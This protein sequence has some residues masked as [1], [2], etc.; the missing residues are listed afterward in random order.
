MNTKIL[1]ATGILTICGTLFLLS[2]G[3]VQDHAQII[4]ITSG[5]SMLSTLLF[6]VAYH[7]SAIKFYEEQLKKAG[8]HINEVDRKTDPWAAQIALMK[9]SDQEL[10]HKPLINRTAILYGALIM[11]EVGETLLA[12]AQAIEASS[13]GKGSGFY[14]IAQQYAR[15]GVSLQAKSKQMRQ[16]I[17]DSRDK[18]I[19]ALIPQDIAISL[20]DGVTDIVVVT[21]G[22]AAAVGLPA[23]QAYART[24][25][26]NMSKA[27]P[28]TG[29]IEKTADGK[30]I[31]GANYK[32]PKLAD[33]L[34]HIYARYQKKPVT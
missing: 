13:T 9:I 12:L 24:V 33:L 15:E 25:T 6:A 3:I 23:A 29:K 26:S 27:N 14:V 34:L 20:L 30:W 32:P 31:K 1:T 19:G 21:A 11:E 28:Y 5:G 8:K 18:L 16:D 2:L 22:L 10:A 4:A 17:A 7:Y